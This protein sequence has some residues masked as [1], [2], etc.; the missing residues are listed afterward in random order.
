MEQLY[1]NMYASIAHHRLYGSIASDTTTYFAEKDGKPVAALLFRRHKDVVRVLNEQMT[2]E[3]AEIERFARYIFT[4]FA[5]VNIILFHAVEARIERLA[6]P[7][8][9]ATCTEDIVLTLPGTEEEYR[10]NL[11]KATRSYLSRYLNKLKRDIPSFHHAVYEKEEIDEEHVRE[12]IRL[13]RARMAG[14]NKSSYI[15]D[16]EAERIVKLAK[17]CGLVS[18]MTIDGRVCA[19]TIN[20]QVGRNYF[21]KVIAHDSDYNDYRLGTLCCY[22]AICECIRRKGREYHFLWGQYEYKYRLLGVQ[23]NL[24]HISIY[25]S[26]TRLLLNGGAAARTALS[27]YAIDAKNW[28]QHQARQKGNQGLPSRFAFYFLSN[29]RNLKQAMSRT[30]AARNHNAGEAGSEAW[31]GQSSRSQSSVSGH[32]A[33]AHGGDRKR[34]PSAG[35]R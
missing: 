9:Q 15:D 3:A 5:D 11:G 30:S 20:Y 4:V 31:R 23:R 8:Q 24:D 12:I 29:L 6:F 1:E 17:E 13:N 34:P 26:H 35:S 10:A 21:L 18:V 27:G 28:L 32:S 33:A 16:E 22:L 14:K 19:G 25:R 7:Y 2:I